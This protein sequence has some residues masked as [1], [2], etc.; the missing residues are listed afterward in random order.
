MG[1]FATTVPLYERYRP[2]YPAEFFE[3][4]ARREGFSKAHSLIDLGT[5]PGLLALGFA[6]YVG[7]IVGVDPEPAMLAAAS[8][9][10]SRASQPLTLIE[11]KAEAL[12]ADIGS[13]DVVTVGRALHWMETG[14]T[15]A[16]LDRLVG[17]KGTILVCASRT[18]PGAENPWLEA[19]N[20][21]RRAWS[22][23]TAA[24]RH[25]HDL[26]LILS[27]TR[28][29]IVDAIVVESRHRIG[30][31]DLS[32]RTLTFSSSSPAILGDRAQDMLDAI[33][34]E[35]LP[36]SEAGVVTEIVVSTAQVAR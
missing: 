24:G 9:A 35:L 32:L 20:E 1:R 6:P 5:G 23:P 7:R 16:L 11:S 36:F 22:A 10:A 28:F 12:P 33:E 3:T 27:G 26:D 15:A 21:A 34:A 4:V 18:A 2:P 19:Y 13:Y 14:P 17:P 29:A 30:V 25:H 8:A 31:R